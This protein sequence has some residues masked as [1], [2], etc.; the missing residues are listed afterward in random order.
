[1]TE[2]T[3]WG[4]VGRGYSTIL[5]YSRRGES[6]EEF[7]INQENDKVASELGDQGGPV[8]LGGGKLVTSSK[9][10]VKVRAAQGPSQLLAR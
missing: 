4:L 2:E 5:E 10:R 7:W 6:G 1:M 3:I 8:G 9:T